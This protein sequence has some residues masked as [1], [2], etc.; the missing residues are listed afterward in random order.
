[1]YLPEY[2]NLPTD[3]L[4]LFDTNDTKVNKSLLTSS[5]NT[6]T[7]IDHIDDR[8]KMLNVLE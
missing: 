6:K 5:T 3:K 2:H 4:G 8:L 1:M 7:E